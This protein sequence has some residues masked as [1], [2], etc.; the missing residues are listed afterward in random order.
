LFP[1]ENKTDLD[2]ATQEFQQHFGVLALLVIAGIQSPVAFENTEA[3]QRI[4]C[5][6]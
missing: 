6:A 3:L 5:S 4:C 1:V 2:D